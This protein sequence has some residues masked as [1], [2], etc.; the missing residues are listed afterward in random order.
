MGHPFIILCSARICVKAVQCTWR[1]PC[2]LQRKASTTNCIGGKDFTLSDAKANA[3]GLH[4]PA[5]RAH[6][7]RPLKSVAGS[8]GHAV[9]QQLAELKCAL[10]RE[11]RA[12]ASSSSSGDLEVN[13]CRRL[14][15]KTQSDR[16]ST[17]QDQKLQVHEETKAKK[18]DALQ[19][20]L[21]RAGAEPERKQK[22]PKLELRSNNGALRG[23][24]ENP[25]SWTCRV[26]RCCFGYQTQ[27]VLKRLVLF[28]AWFSAQSHPLW[29][30]RV[31]KDGA[32]CCRRC[33][34]HLQLSAIVIGPHQGRPGRGSYIYVYIYIY[35]ILFG[36][37]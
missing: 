14:A 5:P 7:G 19:A 23:M 8:K 11:A 20:D 21:L 18:R 29:H 13:P 17:E 37:V 4:T 27:L 2:A 6:K 31:G 12:V 3:A 16:W 24:L 32:F 34:K 28:E 22:L 30:A 26:V 10:A 9:Q 35:I 1:H 25:G 33:G 15:L 36:V